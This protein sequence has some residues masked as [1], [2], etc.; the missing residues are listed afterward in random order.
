VP[1]QNTI[2]NFRQFLPG[3]LRLLLFPLLFHERTI[4]NLKHNPQIQAF[5]FYAWEPS[6]GGLGG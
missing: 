4:N 2:H 1:I 3:F 5:T 6:R